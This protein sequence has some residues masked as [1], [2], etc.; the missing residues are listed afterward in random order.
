M[1][2]K[3]PVHTLKLGELALSIW[4]RNQNGATSYNVDVYREHKGPDGKW[5]QSHDISPQQEPLKQRLEQYA[6]NWLLKHQTVKQMP[7]SN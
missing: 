3:R 7:N 4:D 5:V 2:K 6:L 1:E